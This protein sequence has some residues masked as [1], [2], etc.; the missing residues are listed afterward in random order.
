M[1]VPVSTTVVEESVRV[2]V[3]MVTSSSP[4]D[5]AVE[6]EAGADE[7]TVD[8]VIGWMLVRSG[9]SLR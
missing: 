2:P 7:T 4:V 1:V 8:K 6:V 5:T 3:M 9:S